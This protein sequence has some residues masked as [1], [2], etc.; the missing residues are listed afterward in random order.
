MIVYT[1]APSDFDYWYMK[2]T[3]TYTASDGKEYRVLETSDEYRC[4]E[5]QIPRYWSGLY[6]ALTEEEFFTKGWA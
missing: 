2:Q 3:G 1:T 5:Y 4:N 6:P